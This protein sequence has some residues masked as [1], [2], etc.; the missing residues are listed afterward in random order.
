MR[1]EGGGG[2]APSVDTGGTA[3]SGVGVLQARASP[4][5]GTRGSATHQKR[6]T[7]KNRKGRQLVA[8]LCGGKRGGST[9]CFD[10]PARCVPMASA[11]MA[12]EAHSVTAALDLRPL[13][14]QSQ[15]FPQNVLPMRLVGRC[16]CSSARFWFTAISW[17]SGGRGGI[18]L[19]RIS[20]AMLGTESHGGA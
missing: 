7:I 17:R 10:G 20:C 19:P 8:H 12:S 1:I 11:F 9:L 13:H 15:S 6:D 3:R 2:P 14:G 4:P 16:W 5:E 18:G